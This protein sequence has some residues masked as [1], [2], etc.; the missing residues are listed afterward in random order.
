MCSHTEQ[1]TTDCGHPQAM[2]ALMATRRFCQRPQ[3]T[4]AKP[5]RPMSGP[6]RTDLQS[7]LPVGTAEPEMQ[8]HGM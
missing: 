4:R 5:P 2:L 6:R 8:L 3:C 1:G 7:A